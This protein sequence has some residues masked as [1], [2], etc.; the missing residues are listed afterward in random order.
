[1][2]KRV[3]HTP[4]SRCSRVKVL[5]S[6]FAFV[7]KVELQP[8]MIWKTVSHHLN[9]GPSGAAVPDLATLVNKRGIVMKMVI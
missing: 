4:V 9:L 7:K 8:V 1:M 2:K 5:R 3:Y 6:F